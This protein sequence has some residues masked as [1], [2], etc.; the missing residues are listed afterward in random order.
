MFCC[1][2]PSPLH[3][4]LNFKDWL[5]YDIKKY[6]TTSNNTQYMSWR[7]INVMTSKYMY[8]VKKLCQMH[9]M[10]SKT[11]HDGTKFLTP[12]CNYMA[13]ACE[14]DT[15]K[16]KYACAERS[17]SILIYMSGTCVGISNKKWDRMASILVN[18][19]LSQ[20][21]DEGMLNRWWTIQ[22][23]IS[24]DRFV[25]SVYSSVILSLQ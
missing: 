9:L 13:S 5:S 3:N 4:I 16:W 8:D 6:V 18:P 12:W 15:R 1:R 25:C 20:L 17:K 24:V 22:K 10:K 7:Q 2:F 23:V 14:A 19:S 21:L 11:C